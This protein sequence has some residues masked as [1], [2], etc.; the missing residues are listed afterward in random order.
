[1]QSLLE[2]P[3]NVATLTAVAGFEHTTA[4]TAATATATA[5][6]FPVTIA[7]S[8]G[9]RPSSGGLT[10]ARSDSGSAA[11]EP[12]SRT[13]PRRAPPPQPPPQLTSSNVGVVPLGLSAGCPRQIKLLPFQQFP[14]FLFLAVAS[15]PL[16]GPLRQIHLSKVSLGGPQA[17]TRSRSRSRSRSG[18]AQTQCHSVRGRH[19]ACKKISAFLGFTRHSRDENE[20]CPAWKLEFVC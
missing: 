11:L 20:L 3:V 6:N 16:T 4:A 18:D 19:S 14:S 10:L 17:S 9:Q 7:P 2:Y 1:M 8:S 5:T 13:P 12:G 15:G